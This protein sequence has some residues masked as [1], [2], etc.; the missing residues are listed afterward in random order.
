[1]STFRRL[2]VAVLFVSLSACSGEEEPIEVSKEVPVHDSPS[3]PDIELFTIEAESFTETIRAT[4]TIAAKQTSRIG[5][6]VEGILEKVYVRVGDRPK[7]GEPLF[8][9]R[10][11]EY[12][13]AA[14]QA[15]A[16]FQ[17][18][19]A[20]LD[21]SIKKLKRAKRLRQDNLLSQD[22]LDLTETSA[23]VARAQFSSAQALLASANQRLEDTVVIA[24]FDG[25]V[26]GRFADEGVYMSNRF[27]MGGQSSVIE[28]SEAGIVAGIM[29]VPE[30]Q[31]PKLKLGQKAILYPGGTREGYESEVFIINDRVDPTTRT[32]EFRLPVR[33]QDYKIKP[34]Q[35][36]HAEVF[37]APREII[38]VPRTAIVEEG[39][40]QFA[41]LKKGNSWARTQVKAIAFNDEF[42]EV[43]EGLTAG[44]KIARLAHL[45][46]ETSLIRAAHH[47]DR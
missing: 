23:R 5:P 37:M 44:Q 2:L 41:L 6:H 9:M 7:K 30:A 42:F 45:V 34:G 20:E 22:D 8:Q 39:G 10:V 35:F 18:A 3:P 19:R 46:N 27:S 36:T 25:T 15:G 31:L 4:G 33:N 1:M 32:A 29:R 16:V 47:V 28:L 17:V 40:H 24:P 26:T 11:A 21:L 38:K 14:D 13:Q 43:Q 12:Q